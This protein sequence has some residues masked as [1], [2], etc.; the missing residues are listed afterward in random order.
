MALPKINSTP[1]FDV[2][3]PST[4]ESVSFRPYLVKEEKVL[5]L[6]FESKDT[7]QAAKAIGNTLNA[8]A[9]DDGFNAFK[10]TTYDVEYIF[11]TLRTKSVG[12][13]SDV[14]IKCSECDTKNDVTIDLE[15][16][17]IKD[18]KIKRE[19]VKLTDS[20][21]VDLSYPQYGLLTNI[22]AEG[23]ALQDGIK[24]IGAC[25][26]AINTEE[27]SFGREDFKPAELEEFM[28]ELTTEQFK[29]LSEFLKDIPK[30]EHGVS[31]KCV[32]CGHEN[33]ATLS[34]MQDFLS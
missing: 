5:M 32:N 6:A 2:I 14:I 22:T 34:G 24:M 21:S 29:K 15:D 28:E 1:E 4:G 18:A 9:Q 16:V 3:V 12:E 17:N 10:C 26:D 31:F 8:C 23:E 25:I 20:V 7:A 11:T 30:L 27:E 33:H 19:T 13:K